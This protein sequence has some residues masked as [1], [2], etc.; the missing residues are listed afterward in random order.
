MDWLALLDLKTV[1]LKRFIANVIAPHP[2]TLGHPLFS[3]RLKDRKRRWQTENQ[4]HPL[5]AVASKVD[6]QN[7]MRSLGYAVPEVYG[8]YPSLD[9]IPRFE[10]LPRNFVLK[11]TMGWSSAGVFLMRDGVDWFSK[12]RLARDDLIRAAKSFTGSGRQGITGP[13]IAEEL[14]VSFDGQGR[15][16]PDYK[17]YCFGPKV[18][19]VQ[20]CN[21]VSLRMRENQ[22]WIRS[23]EWRP[24]PFRLQWALYPD[25]SLP[26]KP[27]FLDEL[28]R[29]AS[30]VGGKLNIFV[31]IDMYATDRGPVF[32][33]FTDFPN[34]GKSFTPR[35]N[36][37]LGSHWKTKDGGM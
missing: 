13:W 3:A 30:D 31:R 19:I 25:P 7:Y 29:I 18:V 4:P 15:P 1:P 2:S 10:D 9:E 34:A 14:L 5:E 22:N 20:I 37:W 36:A 32:G 26:P 27:P 6:G 28:L 11:P 21:R 17:L 8:T 12:R 33:E 23:P 16:A 35:A 24:L